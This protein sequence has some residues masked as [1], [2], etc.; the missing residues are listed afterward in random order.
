MKVTQ[1]TAETNNTKKTE[2]IHFSETNNNETKVQNE[3]N[4]SIFIIA[5][6]NND[7]SPFISSSMYKK[8]INSG[9]G[10]L[11]YQTINI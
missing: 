7:S 10:F 2:T 3:N 4:E 9:N 5:E 11:V 8:I 6:N 1:N